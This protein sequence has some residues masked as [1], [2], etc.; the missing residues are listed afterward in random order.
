MEGPWL[1]FITRLILTN[2]LLVP[3][4]GFGG[5]CGVVVLSYNSKNTRFAAIYK[6]LQGRS[7]R[8]PLLG[9][10]SGGF[11]CLSCFSE[12]GKHNNMQ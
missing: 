2:F 11:S 5:Q 4:D 12:N 1:E 8:E 3:E 9:S 10:D 7:S 6:H